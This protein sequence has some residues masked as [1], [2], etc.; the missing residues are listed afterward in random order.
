M[1]AKKSLLRLLSFCIALAIAIYAFVIEPAWVEIT[2]HSPEQTN[3]ALH[4][5]SW[6]QVPSGSAATKSGLRIAQL[7][8]LHLHRMGRTEESVIEKINILVPDLLLLTGDVADRPESLPVLDKFLGRLNATHKVAILGNWEYWGGVDL[9]TLK[10][11]YARHDVKLLINEC[12]QYSVNGLKVPIAGLDDFTAGNPD[13]SKVVAQCGDRESVI[14]MEHSPGY[15]ST[16]NQTRTIKAYLSLAGHTHA[17]QLSIFG[18]PLW[19]PPGSGSF[20]SGWYVTSYG[21]MYVSRGIGTSVLPFRLGA[22]PEIA[23]FDFRN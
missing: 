21:D 20:V 8:D 11:V 5:Y 19:T 4:N 17:G 18:Y 6:L 3:L 2:Y 14:L 15:F 22:R 9:R 12:V 23:V 1:I 10:D 13:E 7:S 16:T